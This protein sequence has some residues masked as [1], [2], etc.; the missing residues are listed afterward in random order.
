MGKFRQSAG[1]DSKNALESL[2]DFGAKVTQAFHNSLSDLFK[3]DAAALREFSSVVF[4]EVSQVFDSG[5]AN[6]I[7][8]ARFDVAL[9]RKSAPV[10]VVA[11]FLAGN[12]PPA[13][14]VAIE[15]SVVSLG[16]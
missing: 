5:L 13:E 6:V 12:P 7:P 16:S 1:A 15:Q 2:S 14:V 8:A 4:L 9:L 3:T 10:T 11:D